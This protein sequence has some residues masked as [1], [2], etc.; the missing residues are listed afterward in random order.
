MKSTSNTSAAAATRHRARVEDNEHQGRSRPGRAAA[1]AAALAVPQPKSPFV[2]VAILAK[3]VDFVSADIADV[4]PLRAVSP[5]FQQAVRAAPGPWAA[6]KG[7]IGK[8][9]AVMTPAEIL[10]RARL[11]THPKS[12]WAVA[13]LLQ[14][15]GLDV[16]Q[17]VDDGAMRTML[18]HAV[19]AAN[20]PLIAVLAAAKADVKLYWMGGPSPLRAACILYASA[21]KSPIARAVFNKVLSL[22]GMEDQDEREQPAVPARQLDQLGWH[23]N[24]QPLQQLSRTSLCFA[25]FRRVEECTDDDQRNVH[26]EFIQQVSWFHNNCDATA[27]IP[28]LPLE[29]IRTMAA[30]VSKNFVDH[31]DQAH[32]TMLHRI[33]RIA[34]NTCRGQKQTH[35][36]TSLEDY[37]TLIDL[38][39][40]Y[41]GKRPPLGCP[42]SPVADLAAAHAVGTLKIF[43][44]HGYSLLAGRLSAEMRHA[45]FG[46]QPQ[47]AAPRSLLGRASANSSHGG[48]D[49]VDSDAYET[50]KLL[51][52]ANVQWMHDVDFVATEVNPVLRA[53]AAGDVPLLRKLCADCNC[54]CLVTELVTLSGLYGARGEKLTPLQLAAS[55]ANKALVEAL[56]ELGAPVDKLAMRYAKE[57]T[58][59]EAAEV[60]K[61]LKSKQK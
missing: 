33:V 60:V 20:L 37:A 4:V 47:L 46:A 13:T 58:T 39:L 35:F 5:A 23:H 59:P 48:T 14:Q 11:L 38:L 12:S 57:Q 22:E 7:A 25:I 34:L 15:H 19:S 49:L 6:V 44:K 61:F 8:T 24:N 30:T 2:S 9:Q 17:S 29:A 1:A 31:L 51:A 56:V 28:R 43:I 10:L 16:N 36:K 32:D 21:P 50:I 42:W 45:G 3:I 27:P 18:S 54:D 41:G 55:I 52:D 53:T 26:G 40:E